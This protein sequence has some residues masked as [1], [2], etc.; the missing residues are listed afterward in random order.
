M[1]PAIILTVMCFARFSFAKYYLGELIPEII[2]ITF[3]QCL[4]DIL[5][6]LTGSTHIIPKEF[7]YIPYYRIKVW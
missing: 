5:I 1:I 6:Y 4:D 7:K 2:P 3:V